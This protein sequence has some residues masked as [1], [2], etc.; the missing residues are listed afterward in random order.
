MLYLFVGKDNYSLNQ[1]L[2]ELKTGLNAGELLEANT[3]NIDG[4]RT[5]P[6][7]V[8]LVV[9]ALPFLAS[10]RL[11]IVDGLLE[12]FDKTA[13]RAKRGKNKTAAGSPDSPQSFAEVLLQKP[14]TTILVLTAGEVSRSNPLFKRLQSEAVLNEFPLL[15][16][17]ELATWVKQ[18]VAL[19]GAAITPEAARALAEQV[20]GELWAMANEIDKLVAYAGGRQISVTDIGCLVAWSPEASIF[21][22]VDSVIEG[23]ASQAE[24][25]LE[26]LLS[27]GMN[28]G[29]ILAMLS[30]QVRM[31]TLARDMIERGLSQSE[32][33]A[34][35]GITHDFVLRKTL[36]QA[37]RHTI[38]RLKLFYK[39]LVE[40]DFTIKTSRLEPELAL[41]V[42]VESLARN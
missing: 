15:K 9:S 40:A 24:A 37:R 33:Q 8:S 34:R 22:M 20:G 3:V 6:G 7:E 41:S 36:Q 14:D 18:Q 12:R 38:E 32:I 35:L 17:T 29:Q 4:R 39:R 21:K 42:L 31:I 30:R 25:E 23:K 10:K 27:E 13:D 28:S 26:I 2:R 16:D 19:R 11:V 5:T 1:A